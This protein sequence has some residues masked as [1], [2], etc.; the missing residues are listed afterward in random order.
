MDTKIDKNSF[1]EDKDL[2]NLVNLTDNEA[3]I[4]QDFETQV[5]YNEGWSGL[6][7]GF[8]RVYIEDIDEDDST[9]LLGIIKCGLQDGEENR[10]YTDN[11]VFHRQT[12]EINYL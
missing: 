5:L 9:T 10:V 12:G 7:G 1:F 8:A 11:F 3:K 2:Q 4:L 6:S